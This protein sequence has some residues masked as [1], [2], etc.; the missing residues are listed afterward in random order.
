M[1]L[2]GGAGA[3]GRA[4]PLTARCGRYH[5]ESET[6]GRT[7]QQLRPSY[8]LRARFSGGTQGSS[9]GNA[10]QSARS[11]TASYSVPS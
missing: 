7:A 6:E 10:C 5:G 11:A 9:A 1:N 4:R 2:A 8:L 3:D